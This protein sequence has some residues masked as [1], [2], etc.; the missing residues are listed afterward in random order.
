M[1]H[2]LRAHDGIVLAPVLKQ[3]DTL[4]DALHRGNPAMLAINTAI[5]TTSEQSYHLTKLHT[6][7]L[8][9]KATLS[10]KQAELNAKLTG[11]RQERKKLLCNEDIN[12]QMNTL[13][14]TID[15]IRNGPETLSSFDEALF[16]KLVDRIVVDT[17]GIIH[18]QLYGG[19]EFQETLEA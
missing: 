5:A 4:S 9:D 12:E 18:F 2:K 15:A 6:A 3:V 19:L 8:L 7:G 14:L 16:T 11:L 13:H 1:Y 17:Q 10:A